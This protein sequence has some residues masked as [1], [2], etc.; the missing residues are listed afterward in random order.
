M[1]GC[2]TGRP[3]CLSLFRM[4]SCKIKSVLKKITAAE[5]NKEDYAQYDQSSIRFLFY[6]F[7]FLFCLHR[8]AISKMFHNFAGGDHLF[9]N[10]LLQE[11]CKVEYVA[12]SHANTTVPQCFGEFYNQQREWYQSLVLD[13][14]GRLKNWETFTSKSDQTS[15]LYIPYRTFVIIYS[16]LTPGIVFLVIFG[17]MS[18]AFPSIPASVIF[19]INAFVILTFVLVCFKASTCKNTQVNLC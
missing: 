6:Q 4:S 13:F 15:I 16:I 14:V 17:S 1:I 10:I 9:F 7:I 12:V 19:S 8:H 3:G 2:V 11:G 5:T 18:M